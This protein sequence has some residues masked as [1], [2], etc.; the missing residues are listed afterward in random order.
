MERTTTRETRNRELSRP[1]VAEAIPYAAKIGL[2]VSDTQD[3]IHRVEQGFSYQAF[4]KMRGLLDLSASELTMLL[5]IPQRTLTRRRQAGK[6]APDESE[7]ILRLSRVLDAAVELFEGDRRAAV[8]WLQ[9]PNRAIGG[10][11][12]LEMARTEIGAREVESV[13]G[14]LEHGVSS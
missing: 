10:E 14:R 3:L 5:Q 1:G 11:A 4:E 2:R 12:P 13:I 9:S 6:F 7:R 8:E